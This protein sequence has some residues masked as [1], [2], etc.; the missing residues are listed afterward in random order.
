MHLCAKDDTLRT[1]S[2]GGL[3]ACACVV[4]TCENGVRGGARCC[5]RHNCVPAGCWAQLWRSV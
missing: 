4:H 2:D 5:I 3:I 1:V